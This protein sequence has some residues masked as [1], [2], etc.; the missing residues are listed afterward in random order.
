[1][2]TLNQLFLENAVGKIAPCIFGIKFVEIVSKRELEYA[3]E[4][5]KEL[6]YNEEDSSYSLNKRV[7]D[8]MVE[9]GLKLKNT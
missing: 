1:M 2:K 6:C 5:L 4:I 9:L 3:F 8:K 7:E